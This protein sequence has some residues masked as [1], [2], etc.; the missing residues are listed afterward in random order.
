MQ[1]WLHLCSCVNML[2]VVSKAVSSCK[3]RVSE[4]HPAPKPRAWWTFA[5][6]LLELQCSDTAEVWWWGLLHRLA[7]KMRA[8]GILWLVFKERNQAWQRVY[9]L[10]PT[11][12]V[13]LGRYTVLWMVLLHP[14]SNSTAAACTVWVLLLIS[15]LNSSDPG[16]AQQAIQA[17]LKYEMKAKWKGQRRKRMFKQCNKWLKILKIVLNPCL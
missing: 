16:N 10:S 15:P 14:C 13:P 5:A 1:E 8:L 9:L 11:L 12:P 2:L 3:P 17:V 6:P 4:T 7:A